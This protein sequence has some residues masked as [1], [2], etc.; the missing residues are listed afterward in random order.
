MDLRSYI[1]NV[2]DFPKEGIMFK[3]ITPMLKDKDAFMYAIDSIKDNYKDVE[4]DYIVGI[5]SRGFIVG[6]PLAYAMEKG[7]IPIRKPGK[8]PADKITTS[9]DL[10]YGSNELELHRD[11]IE[12]GDK[13]LI[14]DDLLATGGTV[15]ASCELVEELGGDIVGIGF[16]LELEDLNGRDKLKGYDVFSLL[17]D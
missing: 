5:E 2:P 8:L 15:Q 14:I 17:K 9:Y 7:F 1:R 12:E 16:L 11:A 13:I 4:I 6:T 3:D 10:E